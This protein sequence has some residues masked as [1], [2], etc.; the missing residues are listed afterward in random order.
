MHVAEYI[1]TRKED[2]ILVAGDLND[3]AWS[4]TTR[5]FRRVSGTLD[6]RIGRGMFN[7][8]HANYLFLR[9]PLDHFFHTKKLMISEIERLEHVGSDHFPLWAKF[10]ILKNTTNKQ[11][12][13]TEEHGDKKEMEQLQDRGED[14]VSPDQNKDDPLDE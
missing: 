1:N 7:T 8:F 3:V 4:H 2:A 11:K 13:E 6:P 12:P 14:W 5:L 10:Y 9:Y